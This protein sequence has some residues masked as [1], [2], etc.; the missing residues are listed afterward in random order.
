MPEAADV[1]KAILKNASVLLV[2]NFA[3]ELKLAVDACDTDAG[4][5]LLQQDSNSVDPVFYF[6]K[7][8][9]KHQRN[10]STVEKECI[11]LILSLQH[12]KIYLTTSSAPII[13]FSDHNSLYTYINKFIVCLY[14]WNN[15]EGKRIIWNFSSV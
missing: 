15:L 3:K 14:K 9:S 8:F 12:F 6:S 1:F 5:V 7:Q 10:Y 2:P 11:S 4:S 13:V